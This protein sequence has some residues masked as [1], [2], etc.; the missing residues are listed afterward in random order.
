MWSVYTQGVGGAMV[1]DYHVKQAEEFYTRDGK[2]PS[3]HRDAYFEAES[4]QQA[5]DL[6]FGD[7]TDSSA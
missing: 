3:V 4:E 5:L 1:C 7:E 2:T 6:R